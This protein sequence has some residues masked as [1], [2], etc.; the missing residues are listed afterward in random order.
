MLIVTFIFFILSLSV[1]LPAAIATI[2]LNIVKLKGKYPFVVF[3]A[4]IAIGLTIGAFVLALIENYACNWVSFGLGVGSVVVGL[5][6][7][8]GTSYLISQNRNAPVQYA[9]QPQQQPVQINNNP[10]PNK[11]RD[12]SYIDEIKQLKEL[13]DCGALTQEEFDARKK[14]ILETR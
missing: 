12:Y 4:V 14:K 2:V 10:Q 3:F 13:L 11:G 8:L 9:S 7:L 5:L 1:G 6:A